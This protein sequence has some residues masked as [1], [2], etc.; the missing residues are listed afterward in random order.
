MDVALGLGRISAGRNVK[1]VYSRQK[2]DSKRGKM[3]VL[4]EK[5]QIVWSLVGDTS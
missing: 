5:S 1:E 3:Q 2:G 4:L